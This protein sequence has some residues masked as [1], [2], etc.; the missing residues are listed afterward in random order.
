[1]YPTERSE[2]IADKLGRSKMSV[3]HKA[4][5]LGI[6]KSEE[7]N[8]NKIEIADTP[9]FDDDF[10]YFVSGFVAGEG[11]FGFRDASTRNSKRFCL[12][13]TLTEDDSDIL[14]DIKEHFNSIGN[15]YHNEARKDS[16]EPEV[17]YLIQSIGELIGVIVP[18]FDEYGLQNTLKQD[19]Y[20]EWRSEL[21]AYYEDRK[22]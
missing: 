3:K 9:N 15:I 6:E 8:T 7:F 4:R 13:I 19:Q 10:S 18:F 11:H 20:N 22:I 14:Y 2:L 17:Q 21:M 12:Q 16:W 5:R 1:M